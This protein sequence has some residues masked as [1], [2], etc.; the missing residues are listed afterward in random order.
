MIHIQAKQK[1]HK[2]FNRFLYHLIFETLNV[3]LLNQSRINLPI[4]NIINTKTTVHINHHNHTDTDHHINILIQITNI[5]TN[6]TTM[7]HIN[8]GRL[9]FI[10]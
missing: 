1:Y 5:H 8:Q 6:T 3:I 7:N 10:F 4:I 2:N 9:F